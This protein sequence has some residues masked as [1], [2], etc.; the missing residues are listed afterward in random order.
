MTKNEKWMIYHCDN[1]GSVFN[2]HC[3]EDFVDF[4]NVV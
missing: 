1:S 2:C 4:F 3:L